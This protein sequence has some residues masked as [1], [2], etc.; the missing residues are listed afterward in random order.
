MT[1]CF[2][3]NESGLLQERHIQYL[4]PSL[5]GRNKWLAVG[6]PLV[7]SPLLFLLPNRALA[8]VL[9][10][11][12]SHSL[13]PHI[14]RA[15]LAL[16]YVE[17]Q[18]DI[19]S[20]DLHSPLLQ[21]IIVPPLKHHSALRE[22]RTF[23]TAHKGP[24]LNVRRTSTQIAFYYQWKYHRKKANDS[25]RFLLIFKNFNVGKTF[26]SVLIISGKSNDG[27]NSHCVGIC[28]SETSSAFDNIKPA[29]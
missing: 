16:E 25:H 27:E 6:C 13:W 18:P 8:L 11:S 2:R 21:R 15:F 24:L 7:S 5:V 19:L 14:A 22:C 3:H 9:L 29:T 28:D 12:Y 1:G 10:L 23:G 17:P 4:T 26:S 20:H